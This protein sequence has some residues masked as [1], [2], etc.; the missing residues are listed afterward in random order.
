MLD[1]G[2]AVRDLREVS[3]PELFLLGVA[4]GA[5]VGRHHRQLVGT[6]TPPEH[7][8]VLTGPKRG[9]ADELGAL[10][11]RPRHVVLREEEIL[12]ARLGKGVLAP[13]AR[14]HNGVERWFRGEVDDV[15][16]RLGDL[17][18]TDGSCRRLALQLGRAGETVE[19]RVGLA[20]GEGV[21][22]DGVDGDA[23]LGV[24]H[25]EGAVARRPVHGP[26]DVLVGGVEHSRVGHEELEARDALGDERVHLLERRLIDVGDDG[27][28]GV[29]DRADAV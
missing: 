12:R 3:D 16:R 19:D 17:G 13:R 7:R 24:H 22:D 9:R 27:V 8:V 28:Q 26:V 20:A 11:P 4:E 14:L 23:V 5:V 10:E 18:E 25:D 21:L 15:E 6:Q 2:Q 1:T 29:V